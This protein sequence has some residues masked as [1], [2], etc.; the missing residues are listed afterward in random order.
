MIASYATFDIP[1]APKLTAGQEKKRAQEWAAKA[2][3]NRRRERAALRRR[4]S[5][6]QALTGHTITNVRVKIR[7][8]DVLEAV[9]ILTLDNGTT[10]EITGR[11]SGYEVDDISPHLRKRR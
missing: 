10:V 4:A 3:Q 9:A 6:L 1:P 11:A 7:D 5:T 8:G 2:A